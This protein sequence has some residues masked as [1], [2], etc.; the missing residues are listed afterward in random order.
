MSERRGFL[1]EPES[2]VPQ[3]VASP[4]SLERGWVP[5]AEG[6][7]GPVRHDA[8]AALPGKEVKDATQ[9][10]TIAALSVLFLIVGVALL[11]LANFT[12]AQFGKAPWLGWLTVGLLTPAC[13]ALAWSM[14][15]EWRGFAALKAVDRIRE[16]LRSEDIAVARASAHEWLN[17]IGAPP[18][19]LRVVQGA[20]DAATLRSLLRTGPLAQL[21]EES[22]AAGRAAALQVLAATAVSPWPGVDGVIVVW[23]GLRLVRHVARL[24]GLRPGTLGTLRLFRRVA[25]DASMV[26]AADIAVSALAEAVFNSP[27]GG[28][29]AGQA[30]GSAVAA[31]RMLRLSFAVAQCC[32]PIT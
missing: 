11:E 16:G 21:T 18:E 22:S 28:A 3:T 14:A 25:M 13:G 31:R 15:R 12:V 23:Q 20:D 8:A 30:T 4:V 6:K 19:T 2:Q 7:E 1:D 27:V 26:A 32:R 29:L 5:G 24:H 10:L 17:A 9:P